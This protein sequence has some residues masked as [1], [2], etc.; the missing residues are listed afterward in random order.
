MSPHL[1]PW[2]LLPGIVAIFH[3]WPVHG[4]LSSGFCLLALGGPLG[5]LRS[6][7]KLHVAAGTFGLS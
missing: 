6:L 7:V 2:M 5:Q 3:I 4:A 1:A